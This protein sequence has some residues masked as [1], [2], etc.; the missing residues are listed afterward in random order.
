MK[1]SYQFVI[2]MI[3]FNSMSYFYAMNSPIECDAV[4]ALLD[5][6]SGQS[7]KNDSAHNNFMQQRHQD[8]MQSLLLGLFVRVDKQDSMI[9]G[10]KNNAE[11]DHILIEQL[12]KQLHDAQSADQHKNERLGDI[13]NSLDEGKVVQQKTL[14]KV[15][16]MHAKFKILVKDVKNQSIKLSKIKKTVN[17]FEGSMDT[18]QELVSCVEGV[19]QN[20]RSQAVAFSKIKNEVNCLKKPSTR[21]SDTAKLASDMKKIEAELVCMKEIL[22]AQVV[23]LNATKQ[24]VNEHSDDLDMLEDKVDANTSS[25]KLRL[26]QIMTLRSS[27]IQ[28]FHAFAHIINHHTAFDKTLDYAFGNLN[29]TFSNALDDL[30]TNMLLIKNELEDQIEQLKIGHHGIFNLAENPLVSSLSSAA[31]SRSQ[32]Y[33]HTQTLHPLAL[34][35]DGIS[36][37]N[38]EQSLDSLS[39]LEED[40]DLD[41]YNDLNIDGQSLSLVSS[42]SSSNASQCIQ[43]ETSA[44]TMMQLS[45]NKR[46]RDTTN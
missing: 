2:V 29:Q 9:A 33:Y 31:P 15:N 19:V 30:E 5:L 41:D 17:K 35:T 14:H 1:H 24:L 20:V 36:H 8:S 37:E 22:H 44:S 34:Q 32:F 25:N 23:G 27:I 28:Q 3:I 18:Y 4:A 16:T 11:Q 6:Q 43:G 7:Y 39:C 13:K 45:G 42:S 21:S 38:V 46:L 26:E 40:F 10:L 12:Q